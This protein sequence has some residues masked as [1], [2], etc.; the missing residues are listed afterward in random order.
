[1]T[2][3]DKHIE[4]GAS[5]HEDLKEQVS[6]KKG[7]RSLNELESWSKDGQLTLNPIWQRNQ[8]WTPTR[9]SLFIE[10][11]LMDMPIPV[12]YLS[13]NNESK[14]DVIDGQ[15]RLSAVFD[16]FDGKYKL[17][18][19][20]IMEDLNG[21][22]FIDLQP[23]LQRK[24]RN[25]LISTVEVSIAAPK[26]MFEM[27][28]RLNTGGV[29]LNEMEIRNC[30]YQ[31]TLNDLIKELAQHS[32]F[33]DC[34][35]Q[36]N[37][38]KRMKDRDLVLRFLAFYQLGYKNARKG[39]KA[40][41]NELCDAYRDAKPEKLN[42]YRKSFKNAVKAAFTIFGNR[43]FRLKL[44]GQKGGGINASVFQVITVSFTEY[45]LGQLTRSADSIYE[46]YLDLIETDTEWIDCVS[47]QTNAPKRI[48]KAFETWNARLKEAVKDSEPNDSKRLFS[49]ELKEDMFKQNNQVCVICRQKISHINDAVLDHDKHYWRGGQT[50]PENARLVHRTCNARRPNDE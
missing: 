46:E 36:K 13:L 20:D 21:C 2:D 44:H 1:M 18:N 4:D 33:V 10:S 22:K 48:L 23:S 49:R 43:G 40:F 28:H 11:L 35:N 26:L 39:I 8:V 37:L 24:L 32:D 17:R 29:K 50:V 31:G 3:D 16:F 12:I 14:Y 27:F 5:K 6:S 45:D 7:E 9:S 34:V 38:S 42:E 47:T 25:Y 19:L 30:I 41:L 15:Q